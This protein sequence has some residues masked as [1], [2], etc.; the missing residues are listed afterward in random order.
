MVYKSP[1]IDLRVQIASTR[2]ILRI[3]S[4]NC[5]F[6]SDRPHTS[7]AG[8]T[9]F[10]FLALVDFVSEKNE[11]PTMH[12]IPERG[13]RSQMLHK[14]PDSLRKLRRNIAN[15]LMSEARPALV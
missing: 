6:L 11:L 7:P 12:P 14:V 4:F 5:R 15:F 3:Q 9:A 1:R 8:L 10:L 13:R 2:N